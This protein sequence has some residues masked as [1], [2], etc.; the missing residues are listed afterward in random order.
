M[1]TLQIGMNWFPSEGGSGLDRM[2]YG[3]VEHLPTLG[4]RTRGL[5]HGGDGQ[6][7][8]AAANLHAFSSR[9]D[10]VLRRLWGVRRAVSTELEE[11][12]FD[13]VAAHFPLYALPILD[14]VGGAVPLVVHFHGPWAFES[15]TAGAGAV[16]ARVKSLIETGVYRRADRFIVLSRAFRN[17][18]VRRYDVNPS[19]V[20]VVPGGV[21][22]DRFRCQRS[23]SD[24]R[25]HMGWPVDRPII[26]SVRR[27]VK[28]VGLESLVSAMERVRARV[29][30][31]LLL[32]AGRGPRA[33]SLERQIRD[34]ELHDHVR[35]VGFVPDDDLPVAYRAAD[36][37]VMPTRALEGF[38]LSAV[39]SL[40]AGTP[41]VVTPVGGLPEVV[42]DLSEELI[43]G[44]GSPEALAARLAAVLQGKIDLPTSSAC[45]RYARSRFAWPVV[46]SQT[47]DVYEQVIQ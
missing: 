26:L 40:A 18:L 21:D 8:H 35:L 7:E 17:L 16:E 36:I 41:V 14:R 44:D 4:V 2:F 5:V 42:G 24:A 3:L 33:E 37:S 38:G 25:E 23:Q 27:L 10:S 29:P 19:R 30:D 31:V 32:M 13:L 43:V 1:R 47:Q 11:R 6:L 28:R 46:A 45:R 39:E 34:A 20:D 15:A 9:D 22:V 12:H